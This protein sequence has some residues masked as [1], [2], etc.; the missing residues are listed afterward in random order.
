MCHA[1]EVCVP[2]LIT[3]SKVPAPVAAATSVLIVLVNAVAAAST[4]ISELSSEGGGAAMVVP[5]NLVC[6][7]VPGNY[8]TTC[9]RHMTG[10]IS[11]RHFSALLQA[12]TNAEM[13]LSPRATRD[14]M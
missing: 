4:Q 10:L 12:I 6:W 11:V 9:H 3:V 1:G 13:Q 7:L 8:L 5:F 14:R 2:Q